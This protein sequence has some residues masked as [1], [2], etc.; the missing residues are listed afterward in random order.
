MSFQTKVG[1]NQ[2]MNDYDPIPYPRHFYSYLGYQL[3][4]GLLASLRRHDPATG[5][6]KDTQCH[7]FPKS[8]VTPTFNFLTEHIFH[9]VSIVEEI[10]HFRVGHIY[11]IKKRALWCSALT[12]LMPFFRSRHIL[13]IW[14]FFHSLSLLP[15]SQDEIVFHDIPALP[16]MRR[17]ESMVWSYSF[18][19]VPQP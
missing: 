16:W 2:W 6:R 5:G 12:E 7:L 10:A 14:L 11:S 1:W 19:S 9:C 3:Y 15:L 8:P 4:T 18:L 17:I 13:I